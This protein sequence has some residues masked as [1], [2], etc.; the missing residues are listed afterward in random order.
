[1]INKIPNSKRYY[2]YGIFI[3]IPLV[4][5]IIGIILLRKGV[6]LKDRILKYIGLGGIAF[7]VAFYALAFYYGNHSQKAKEQQVIFARYLLDR[8]MQEIEIYKL[9]NG[10]YPDSLQALKFQDIH[11]PIVDPLSQHFFSKK[12]AYFNY[13]KIGD[14]NYT[15]FSSGLDQIPYT[16]DDVYPDL[17]TFRLKK[18]GLLKSGK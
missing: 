10:Y 17:S 18:F 1:M 6:I 5:F 3:I 11:A 4:G 8:T 2:K 14:S 15:L 7:T 12:F 16:A 13:K 9:G